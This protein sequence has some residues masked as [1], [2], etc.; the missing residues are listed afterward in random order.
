MIQWII[1]L[2]TWPYYLYRDVV[3]ENE[4]NKKSGQG[5]GLSNVIGWLLFMLVG[6]TVAWQLNLVGGVLL[7]M[8]SFVTLFLNRES[9][10]MIIRLLLLAALSILL[11]VLLSFTGL[12]SIGVNGGFI[13]VTTVTMTILYIFGSRFLEDRIS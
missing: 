5:I 12:Y 13:V 3:K 11:S 4:R 9:M 6:I 8:I 1:S 2:F 10:F 7:I